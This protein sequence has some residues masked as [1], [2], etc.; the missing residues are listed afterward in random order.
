MSSNNRVSSMDNNPLAELADDLPKTGLATAARSAA[1]QKAARLR[2]GY[3]VTSLSLPNEQL[4]W[5]AETAL[6]STNDEGIVTNKT[7]VIKALVDV[8]RRVKLDL[9]G[10]QREEEIAE[11]LVEAIKRRY[12]NQ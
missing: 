3:R 8:A 6:R 2:P 5:L 1:E 12:I 9:A 7:M 11:R 10:L 4:Q